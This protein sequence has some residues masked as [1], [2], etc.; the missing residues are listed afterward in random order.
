M[1]LPDGTIVKLRRSLYVLK[2]APRIWYKTLWKDLEAAGYMN[3]KTAPCVFVN[4]EKDT[5]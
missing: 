5:Y 3:S 1:I 4:K 2:Q